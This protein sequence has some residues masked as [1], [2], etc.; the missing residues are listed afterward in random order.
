MS[1]HK[2]VQFGPS[3]NTRQLAMSCLTIWSNAHE[4]A[5]KKLKSSVSQ[6]L[7]RKY[8]QP[9]IHWITLK[10][11]KQTCAFLQQPLK[12]IRIMQVKL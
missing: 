10:H 5:M 1:T 8:D 6:T 9:H 2:I 12:R 7:A 3:S 11:V 4:I